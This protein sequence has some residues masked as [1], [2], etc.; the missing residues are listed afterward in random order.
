MM[1]SDYGNGLWYKKNGMRGGGE[2]GR[3]G[4]R[5]GP[6]HITQLSMKFHMLIRI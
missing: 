6:A 5:F 3:A 1:P 2:G 4:V